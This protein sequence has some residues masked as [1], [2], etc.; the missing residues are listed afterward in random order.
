MSA[1]PEVTVCVSTRNRAAR[2]PRLVACLES[3]TI[4]ADRMEAVIVDNGSTDDTWEVLT[5]LAARAQFELRVYRNPPG[6]GPAAGRNRAWRDAR[7]A[8]CAFTDDDCAPTSRWLEAAVTAIGGRHIVAAGAVSPA[9][10]DRDLIG[11]FTR[12]TFANEA[13]ARWGATANLIVRKDDLEAIDGFD[14]SF[15]NVA[16]EDT[17][18]MLRVIAQGAEFDFLHHALVF[19]D[20]DQ[21]GVRGMLRD[22]RRWVDIPGVFRKHPQARAE[23]LHHGIFWKESHPWTILLLAG[24]AAMPK[25]RAA[26]ALLALPWIHSRTC[27]QSPLQS[28]AERVASLPGLLAMDV[29]ELVLMVRGSIRHRTLML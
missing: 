11:P 14:E 10:A 29:H 12:W 27:H 4:G 20:I 19:H 15:L 3:Q 5:D 28:Y 13:I 7:A 26:A 1:V 25:S 21:V 17:D 9:P 8:L 2:L 24:L 18:M 23:L 16:G 6:K 22:Q